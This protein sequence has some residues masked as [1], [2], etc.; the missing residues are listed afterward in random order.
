MHNPKRNQ[1]WVKALAQLPGHVRQSPSRLR[2]LVEKRAA[3]CVFAAAGDHRG[4]VRNQGV[5]A[6]VHTNEN[7]ASGPRGPKNRPKQS[8]AES[9][10]ADGQQPG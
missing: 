5:D 7:D 6:K 2:Q 3:N 8:W 4:Q 10:P 1:V 9:D